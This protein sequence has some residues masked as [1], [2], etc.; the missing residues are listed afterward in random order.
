MLFAW[1]HI[2]IASLTS[3]SIY[4]AVLASTA[5]SVGFIR[6]PD[7]VLCFAT[8]DLSGWYWC[9]CLVMFFS[10]SLNRSTCLR[11]ATKAPWYVSNRQIYEDFGFTFFADHIRALTENS[12]LEIRR[13]WEPLCS[14]TWKALVPTKGWL[15]LRKRT[16]CRQTSRC[17]P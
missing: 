11:I 15:K 4:P 8:V 9:R 5:V 3:L 17:F 14:A 16:V 2:S 10:F 12:W 6:W 1:R 13:Y 7:S